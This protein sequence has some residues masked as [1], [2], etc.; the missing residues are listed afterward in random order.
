MQD[1]LS[2]K[3]SSFYLCKLVKEEEKSSACM[4]AREDKADDITYRHGHMDSKNE[5]THILEL[6]EKHPS[7]RSHPIKP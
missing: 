5:M 6:L 4:H 2:I 1:A 7:K 3:F